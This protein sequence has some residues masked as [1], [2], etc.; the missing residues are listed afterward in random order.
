MNKLYKLV[1]LSFL[2][3]FF[4]VLNVSGQGFN[5]KFKYWSIGG[6]LNVMNY[7]G[8]LDPGPSFLSPGIK[9]TRYNF[10]A[11]VM[12]RMGPRLSV[13]GTFSFGRI[14]G[15]DAVNSTYSTK[16]GASADINRKSRNL[17]FFNNIYELKGDVVFDLIEHRGRYQKRPDFVPYLFAGLAYFHHNPKTE[18]NGSTVALRDKHTEG[19][20]ILDGAPKQYSLHQIA[21]PI[22][23]GLRYKL[24]K[25]LDLA[26]EIGWR[27]TTT[28]YLDDVSDAY[29]DAQALYNATGDINSVMLAYRG[30]EVSGDLNFASALPLNTIT[31]VRDPNDPTQNVTFNTWG[32]ARPGGP[33]GTRKDRDAYIITGFHLMYIIPS[34][35]ICPKFR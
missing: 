34:K 16:G 33:R 2:F 22:G 26:F 32:D 29:P 12:R 8:E 10:G 3:S 14:K 18:Y 23:L 27:F 7:V 30:S 20:G 19:Q 5:S 35:V 28:D 17:S 24:S 15:E 25:Q 13:R 31:V 21:L 11:V 4:L 9:F 1:L 6:T